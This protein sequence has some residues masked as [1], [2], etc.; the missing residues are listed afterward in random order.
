VLFAIFGGPSTIVHCSLRDEGHHRNLGEDRT[1]VS[2]SS[3]DVVRKVNT[4]SV[5]PYLLL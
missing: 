3:G 4:V 1:K 5:N 2:E